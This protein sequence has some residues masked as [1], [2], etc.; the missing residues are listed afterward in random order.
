MTSSLTLEASA[1]VAAVTFSGVDDT[2]RNA[3]LNMTRP[4]VVPG[5]V[6]P[7]RSPFVQLPPL[8]SSVYWEM[9]EIPA[10]VRFEGISQA[11]VEALYA[12]FRAA[13]ERATYTLTQTINAVPKSYTALRARITPS[14]ITLNDLE[15]FEMTCEVS[16]PVLPQGA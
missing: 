1:G 16:F 11:D 12:L 14:E 10:T 5:F 3:L 7:D 6:T 15:E 2:N 13:A 8:P 9:W 4:A